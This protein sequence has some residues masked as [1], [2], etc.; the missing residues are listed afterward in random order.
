MLLGAPFSLPKKSTYT[1]VY[2]V[3]INYMVLWCVMWVVGHISHENAYSFQF[4]NVG[5]YVLNIHNNN[6]SKT[7]IAWISTKI[8]EL[9]GPSSTGV[10]HTHSPG[11]MQCSSTNDQ[12]KWFP[13]STLSQGKPLVEESCM[14][15]MDTSKPFSLISDSCW[16]AQLMLSVQL[17]LYLHGLWKI[18]WMFW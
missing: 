16:K 14:S 8:I 18:V 7:S 13:S 15:M 12:M 3:S 6:N 1:R 4:S 5:S 2:T 9:S 10:G 17:T 11:T